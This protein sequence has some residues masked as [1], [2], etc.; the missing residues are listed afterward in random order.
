MTERGAEVSTFVC[1][2]LFPLLLLL[3]LLTRVPMPLK[4]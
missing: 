4:R 3:L 2:F 1:S